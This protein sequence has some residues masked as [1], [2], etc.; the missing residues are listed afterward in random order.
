MV[1][2]LETHFG[3]KRR[4][5]DS[6]HSQ[7]LIS[8]SFK[9][10]EHQIRPSSAQIVGRI[11]AGSNANRSKARFTTGIDIPRGIPDNENILWFDALSRDSSALLRCATHEFRAAFSVGS[12]SPKWKITVQ[13]TAL[14]FDPCSLLDI[15]GCK[16]EPEVGPTVEILEEPENPRQD[17]IA[18][19]VLNFF[20]QESNISIKDLGNRVGTLCGGS[21]CGK[22]FPNDRRV[23]FSV[24]PDAVHRV[25][26]ADDFEKGAVECPNAGSTG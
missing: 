5:F 19:R 7:E 15:A 22:N 16:S 23:C 2:R 4:L 20:G 14:E 18:W 6:G 11:V 24:R 21:A 3:V 25:R 26:N 12:E 9:V 13:V 10:G 17:T 8:I 1:R